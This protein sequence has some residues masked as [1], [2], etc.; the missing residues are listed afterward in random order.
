MLA[1]IFLKKRRLA[2]N[3]SRRFLPWHEVKK[4]ALILPEETSLNK[5]AMDDL[6]NSLEKFIDVFY[7]QNTAKIPQFSDW[8]CFTRTDFHWSGVPTRNVMHELG[9]RKYDL[10]MNAGESIHAASVSASIPATF[11]CARTAI[12]GEADFIVNVSKQ[13]TTTGWIGHALSYLKMIRN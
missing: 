6:I 4:I 12:L 5:S 8:R 7:V 10:A 1:K 13:E 11:K 9:V 3:I 2:E